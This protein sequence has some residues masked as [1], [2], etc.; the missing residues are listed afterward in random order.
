[1]VLH[2]AEATLWAEGLALGTITEETTSDAASGVVI[3]Q[4][5]AAGTEIEEG[6]EVA[7]TVAVNDALSTTLKGVV[8]YPGAAKQTGSL[9]L[10]TGLGAWDVAEDGSYSAEAL[11]SGPTLAVVLNEN[12]NP[13]LLAWVD[14]GNTTVDA[15]STAEA[16]TFEAMGGFSFPP[17]ERVRAIAALRGESL[18]TLT[19]A[20]LT[21][22]AEDGDSLASENASVEQILQDTVDAYVAAMP[23]EK[24]LLVDPSGPRSGFQIEQTRG[25]NA[26]QLTN[27]YR[28]RVRVRVYFEGCEGGSPQLLDEFDVPPVTGAGNAIRAF[29]DICGG[30][31]PYD[32]AYSDGICFE[33]RCSPDAT[34]YRIVTMGLG[35]G[36]GD[37]ADLTAEE[38]E[39]QRSVAMNSVAFDLIFPLV[40]D[41]IVPASGYGGSGGINTVEYWE[42]TSSQINDW[43][44]VIYNLAGFAEACGDGDIQEASFI[45]INGLLDNDALKAKTVEMLGEM[46]F[47]ASGGTGN[48]ETSMQN[49]RSAWQGAQ[50]VFN[51]VGVANILLASFD[52]LRMTH[53]V[54]RS[55]RTDIYDVTVQPPEATLTPEESQ[56]APGGI[57][58]L[59]V[60]IAD[61][62]TTGSAGGVPTFEYEWHCTGYTGGISDVDGNTGN[63]TSEQRVVTYEASDPGGGLDT[64][65][66]TVWQIGTCGEGNKTA[67]TTLYATVEV[68]VAGVTVTAAPDLV[69]ADGSESSVIT[70][71]VRR[72]ATGD[73][74]TATG[75]PVENAYIQFDATLGEISGDNPTETDA[76][77]QATISLSSDT[78]GISNV[79][80]T[81]VVDDIPVS[82]DTTVFFGSEVWVSI[83]P[84]SA[85]LKPETTKQFTAMLHG[86]AT[87]DCTGYEYVWT[88]S[89]DFGT[90]APPS[91]AAADTFTT[92]SDTVTF[93]AGS[94]VGADDITVTV[95]C[96]TADG[97]IE[98][99]VGTAEAAVS[100]IEV[101]IKP[102][103]IYIG[104]DDTQ[105]VNVS[106]DGSYGIDTGSG[107]T[108]S[109]NLGGANGTRLTDWNS[110]YR[111]LSVE[112][113]TGFV[114]I[115]VPDFEAIGG[116][117]V[118][119][120]L[121]VSV[122]DTG[123]GDL[124]GKTSAPIILRGYIVAPL[125][126][127]KAGPRYLYEE[128]EAAAFYYC[129]FWQLMAY[130]VYWQKPLESN[131]APW[132]TD[133]MV[134]NDPEGN[135]HSSE[136]YQTGS[137][138][139]PYWNIEGNEELEYQLMS[140]RDD[141]HVDDLG[142]DMQYYAAAFCNS[143]CGFEDLGEAYWTAEI[144][145]V[146][147]AVPDTMKPIPE[148]IKCYF[149]WHPWK[150]DK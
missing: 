4:A 93:T 117:Q 109:W 68:P 10:L 132:D 28:R 131:G 144:L 6:D 8:D 81:A 127:V 126:F 17:S 9:Q 29:L 49:A 99:G 118:E 69:A 147:D 112:S 135:A 95:Y 92:D 111:A 26:I 134:Y 88:C 140:L 27:M 120:T 116:G 38:M 75:D 141:L 84:G 7:L 114:V 101:A 46:V 16:L 80:A 3:A 105:S 100:T 18:D 66:V 139:T 15:R 146:V 130:L 64:I 125:T 1:M 67:I 91:G 108:S 32:Y 55:N 74:L 122:Y 20:I 82:E 63:F 61:S 96:I 78:E 33:P 19:Q 41:V 73:T 124:L 62:E 24:T 83:S 86:L 77:G 87:E 115:H 123:T 37:W 39:E 89:S 79:T 137:L 56:I 25:V 142:D 60:E 149:R 136:T 76:N 5:P 50:Q 129:D 22:L 150:K 110:T 104:A 30:S 72:F 23:E 119:D 103:N 54:A 143:L 43:A 148:G 90:L 58:V 85:V 44:K 2:D 94:E 65:S 47:S 145:E 121:E 12:G 11:A 128:Y 45:A 36:L 31:I 48:L 57:V 70:A 52:V 21:S 102:D 133:I 97:K 34:P 107:Y 106:I 71:T 40:T 42:S 14:A 98:L 138:G 53:D 59:E 13:S 51:A 113:E 35:L